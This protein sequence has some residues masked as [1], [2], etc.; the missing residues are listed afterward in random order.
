MSSAVYYYICNERQFVNSPLCNEIGT[1]RVDWRRPIGEVGQAAAD[2]GV[3]SIIHGVC[4]GASIV[5][6]V[7][8]SD[9]F[10]SK[11]NRLTDC[12]GRQ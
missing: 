2:V 7:V 10:D 5:V 6:G 8:F 3:D 9:A 12:D 11:C 1:Y 4:G